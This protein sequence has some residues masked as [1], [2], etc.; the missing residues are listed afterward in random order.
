MFPQ[1]G[2][3]CAIN[4]G[5]AYRKCVGIQDDQI[6]LVSTGHL[7]C[8]SQHMYYMSKSPVGKTTK[9]PPLNLDSREWEQRTIRVDEVCLKASKGWQEFLNEK[10]NSNG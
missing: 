6:D 9:S 3:G 4:I 10:K 5:L 8:P 7:I 1:C 2:L